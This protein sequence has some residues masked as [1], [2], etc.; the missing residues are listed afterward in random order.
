MRILTYILLAYW[1]FALLNIILNLLL[2]GR[3]RKAALERE[4][5]V[6]IVIP[7]RDEERDI[8][9][10]VRA[11]LVQDYSAFEVIVVDDRSTDSTGAILARIAAEDRRLV[12][13]HGEEPP[14]GWLGKPWAMHQG[15]GRA[16]GEMLL[17]VD[18]DV[19]YAPGTLLTAVEQIEA[20]GVAMLFLYPH[21]EMRGL[22][23]NAVMPAVPL[24]PFMF[25]LWLGERFPLPFLGLGGG[26]GN[27]IRRG[28]YDAVG[29][30]EALCDA[31]VDDVGLAQHVR[32]N[33]HRTGVIRAD[34]LVSVRM[35]HGLDEI[36]RGFTKNAFTAIGRSYLITATFVVILFVGHLLPFILPLVAVVALI[37][38]ARLIFFAAMRYPLWSAVLLH[39]LLAM[40]WIWIVIRSAWITGVRGELA[41]R[42]R[43]YDA[44]RTR[45]GAERDT[46]SSP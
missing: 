39:P 6:S 4:P 21:F 12:V 17:F 38:A 33:G 28:E 3:P 41:W 26:T 44:A 2:I 36:V 8:E 16:R 15:S 11:L 23:E 14:A 13:V 35:Y 27:L 29:G 46:R 25:P 30:H 22:W 1:A 24:T 7:A 42:G 40:I 9:R 19:H 10:T 31:V 5:F 20:S 18:A 32:R 43:T 37:I 34:R 45:F